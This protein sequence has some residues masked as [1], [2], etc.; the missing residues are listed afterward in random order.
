M[1]ATSFNLIE[2]GQNYGWPLIAYGVEYSG[3]PIGPG[4]TS[5]DGL[6]QP[7]YYWDP[8]IAPSGAQWYS[9]DAFPAWK[10][11]LFVGALRERKLVRLV[12][13]GQRVVGE[14]WLLADR[15]K[16]VRDVRQD[17]AGALYLVTDEDD[18]EVWKITPGP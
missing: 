18:G 17:K 16:R 4:T 1:A 10:G 8:V 7:V 13:E 9:G 11:N 15:G 3:R 5:R 12:I 14:E 6:V 2:K